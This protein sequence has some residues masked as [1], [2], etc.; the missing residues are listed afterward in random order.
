MGG[1]TQAKKF[2]SLQR[3]EVS[4]CRSVGRG[5]R[6]SRFSCRE[7]AATREQMRRGGD[8][9]H[10]QPRYDT[11]Y[12]VPAGARASIGSRRRTGGTA[13]GRT[14]PRTQGTSSSSRNVRPEIY[15]VAVNGMFCCPPSSPSWSFTPC[16]TENR[17]K[18]VGLAIMDLRKPE[19][20]M[21][22]F[23]DTKNYSFLTSKL[24]RALQRP[25]PWR[26]H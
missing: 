24:V 9:M 4:R 17:M 11:S 6:A 18:E 2:C 19:L 14:T 25:F 5:G 22:Q 15:V 20:V 13:G 23:T 1:Q 21:T 12:C 16:E 26:I 10:Q 3:W 7:V 8:T